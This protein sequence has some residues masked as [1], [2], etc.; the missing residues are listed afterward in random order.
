MCQSISISQVHD[1][2]VKGKAQN[3]AQLQVKEATF[4]VEKYT[5]P[6]NT[7]VRSGDFV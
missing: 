2:V 3:G 1:C 5:F 7:F 6:Q 4:G